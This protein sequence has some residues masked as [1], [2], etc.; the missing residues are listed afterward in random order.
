MLVLDSLNAQIN[1]HLRLMNEHY[2]KIMFAAR[3]I[4]PAAKIVWI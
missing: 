4:P 3:R 2:Y 1:E